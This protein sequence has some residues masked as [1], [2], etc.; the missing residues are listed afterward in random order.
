MRYIATSPCANAKSDLCFGGFSSTG[1]FPIAHT[2]VS[3]SLFQNCQGLGSL[4]DTVVT[5]F[6]KRGLS[7]ALQTGTAPLTYTVNYNI[8]CDVQAP[9]DNPPEPIVLKNQTHR[10]RTF[11]VTWHHPSACAAVPTP[12]GGCSSPAPPPPPPPVCEGCLPPWKPTW[13]MRRRCVPM[14][15]TSH[16]KRSA[17]LGSQ[18]MNL[19]FG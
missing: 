12:P 15:K 19:G 1:S 13:S 16:S 7:I 17:V 3:G 5:A 18:H 8:V 14:T 10:P 6:G 4:N 2:H 9:S 11:N